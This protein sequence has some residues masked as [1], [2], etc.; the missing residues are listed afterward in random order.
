MYAVTKTLRKESNSKDIN[1]GKPWGFYFPNK[2]NKGDH[3]FCCELWFVELGLQVIANIT[4][5][6]STEY[7]LNYESLN[8]KSQNTYPQL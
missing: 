4:T 3:L 1:M 6:T 5:T 2:M 8:V 7:N